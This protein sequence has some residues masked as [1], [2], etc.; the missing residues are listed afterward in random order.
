[1]TNTSLRRLTVPLSIAAVA[2]G[3]VLSTAGA[4]AAST[5][6]T[7]KG[8]TV[9]DRWGSA[10]VSIVVKNK[11]ITK[12]KST[13]KYETGRSQFIDANAVPQLKQEVLQAQSADISYVSG[14]TITSQA[15]TTS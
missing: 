6:V 10:R 9:D 1:M 15:F 5:S 4:H 11:K 14:A 2:G 8:P 13:V 7:Y 3:S 12:V